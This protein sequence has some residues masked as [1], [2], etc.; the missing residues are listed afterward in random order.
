MG[1]DDIRLA[2]SENRM[3]PGVHAVIKS[4][5][6]AQISNFYASLLQQTVEVAFQPSC[7]RNDYRFI[8]LTVQSSYDMDRHALGTT[9][10]QHRNDMD[11][12]DLIHVSLRRS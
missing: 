5:A 1:V 2:L 8:P 3:L 7:E 11:Y 12:L 10:A 4:R 6:Y 9:R